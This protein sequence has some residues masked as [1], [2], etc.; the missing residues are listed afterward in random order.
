[1]NNDIFFS[2][3][4]SNLPVKIW[5]DYLP[6]DEPKPAISFVHIASPFSRVLNG[7]KTGRNDT[8]RLSLF[9]NSEPELKTLVNQ[10]ENL[11]NTGND[12]YQRVFVIFVERLPNLS[13]DQNFFQAIIDLQTYEG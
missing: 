4:S 13:N 7:S 11:D 8:W 2:Y 12:V 10:V 3:L 6:E 1:M 5:A 9:A